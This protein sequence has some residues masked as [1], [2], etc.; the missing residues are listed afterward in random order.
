MTQKA[1]LEIMKMGNN[2]YLT[3]EAGTGKTYLLNDY[4][5]FLRKKHIPI[6]V[7]AST[8]IAATHLD[9]V[10]IDSWSG[11]GIRDTLTD[12]EIKVYLALINF[13]PCL[14]GLISRK[15]GLHRRTVYDLTDTLIKKGFIGY[16]KQNNRRLFSASNPGRIIEIL[17]EK[18]SLLLPV[19]EKLKEKYSSVKEKEETIFYKGKEGIKAVFEEQLNSKEVLILGASSKAYETLQFYFHWY[20]KKRKEKKIK[21]RIIAQDKAIKRLPLSEIRYLPE[22]YSSPMAINIYGDKVAIILWAKQPVA[23]IIKQKDIA[24]GYR[25]YFE[26]L[27]KIAKEK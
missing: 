16:I 17:R 21:A 8:G 27:W 13:G 19:V 25:N 11:L 20:D 6:A 22:K 15:T 2:V 3:G 18:E 1:A 14:A 10:T 12:N 4:I 26:L 9:G 24:E 5:Q 23:I 7:T